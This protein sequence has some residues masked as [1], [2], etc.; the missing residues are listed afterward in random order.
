MP[1]KQFKSRHSY[2]LECNQQ[3][4]S[5]LVLAAYVDILGKFQIYCNIGS[6]MD[7]VHID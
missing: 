3:L 2:Q 7:K 5:L 4:G 6:Y 1:D